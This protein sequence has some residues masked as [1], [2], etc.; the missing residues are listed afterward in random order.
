MASQHFVTPALYWLLHQ[1]PLWE[2]LPDDVRNY[3]QAIYSLNRDRNN[4]LRHQLLEMIDT[5]SPLGVEPVLLKGAIS[6]ADALYPDIGIRVMSD[7]DLM[8][9]PDRL[10]DCVSALH[11]DRY[12]QAVPI[13]VEGVFLVR[14]SGALPTDTAWLARHHYPALLREDRPA[15]V[16]LH[17][18][19]VL[20]EYSHLLPAE[21]LWHSSRVLD[22]ETRKVRVPS[23]G[24]RL[25]HNFVHAQLVDAGH[26]KG[27]VSLR[28]LRE[29]AALRQ[30]SDL[31]AEVAALAQALDAGAAREA[32]EG[33]VSVCERFLNQPVP[34]AMG[35]SRAG[36][37]EWMRARFHLRYPY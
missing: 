10:R 7:V 11:A 9:P 25:L 27:R 8:V 15:A 33:Y 30:Q 37:S 3:L 22:F 19:A 1:T 36:E 26:A 31:E 34:A 21:A 2:D 35:V 14:P 23:L 6:L 5:L 29:F 13:L 18:A 12:S 20:P 4:A 28:Q 32:F 16:E 24:H 17:Q